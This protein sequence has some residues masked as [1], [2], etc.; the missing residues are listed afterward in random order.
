MRA[1]S[2]LL[3]VILIALTGAAFVPAAAPYLSYA[4]MAAP[5][6]AVLLL[7]LLLASPGAPAEPAAPVSMPRPEPEPVRPAPVPVAENR[8]DAEVISFLALMQ[9]KGRLVDFL[10]DDIAAYGDAQIGAAARVVHAGCRSVLLE[11]LHVRPIRG[12]REGAIVT[13]PAGYAADE[14][15]LTGK[16]GGSPPFSG[17]LVHRGWTAD[18]VS[19]PRRVGGPEDRLPHLAPAEVELR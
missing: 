2:I 12:E 17:T 3:A 10:M 8:A 19:L 11:H 14:Y 6:V 18:S 4:A 15:R 9:E 16:L 1:A 5:A 13:V 7:L